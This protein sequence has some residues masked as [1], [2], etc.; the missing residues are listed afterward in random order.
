MRGL[1]S[2]ELLSVWERGQRESP[3]R[4]ALALLAPVFPGDSAPTLAR[5]PLGERD[6]LLLQLRKLTLGSKLSAIVRCPT[7][8]GELRADLSTDDLCSSAPQEGTAPDT[9]SSGGE[10]PVQARLPTTL[11]LEAAA[12]AADPAIA[13]DLLIARC[14]ATADDA[15]VTEPAAISPRLAAAAAQAIAVADPATDIELAFRCPGCGHHWEEPFDIAEFFWIELQACARRLLGEI[16]EIA[17]AYGW[18]EAEI[19]ALSPARRAS[20]IELIRG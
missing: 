10:R 12:A 18:S 1:T 20:Y 5:L 3:L 6:R 2:A 4:R 14:L 17:G 9:A 8:S 15:A 7:C 16:H 19:L 11:D 13:R